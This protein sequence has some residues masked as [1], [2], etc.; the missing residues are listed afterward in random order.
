MP[1][2]NHLLNYSMAGWLMDPREEPTAFSS[3][4]EY[5]SYLNSE[6]LPLYHRE[7]LPLPTPHQRRSFVVRRRPLKR[8]TV[9]Q[10]QNTTDNEVTKHN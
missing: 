2:T 1:G 6:Y 9:G 10:M 8:A 3:R 5:N 7:T 4:N